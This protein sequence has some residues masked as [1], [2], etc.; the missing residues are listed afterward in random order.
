MARKDLENNLI[1]RA[2]AR[3]NSASE[4]DPSLPGLQA[5][6]KK[7]DD[8]SSASSPTNVSA[9]NKTT[10]AVEGSRNTGKS[11]SAVSEPGPQVTE[12][13]QSTVAGTTGNSESLENGDETLTPGIR[14]TAGDLIVPVMVGLPP[15]AFVMG[16]ESGA[17]NEKPAHQVQVEAFSMSRYEITR[18]QYNVFM[19]DTGSDVDRPPLSQALLPVA[20]IT[21]NEAAAYTRWLSEKTGKR[22]RLPTEEEWEYAARAG[23]MTPYHSGD[24]VFGGANCLTCLDEIPRSAMPVGTFEPNNFGLYDMHGNVAEWTSS[25]LTDN[26]IKDNQNTEQQCT[27]HVVRGGSWRSTRDQVRSS[28]RVGQPVSGRAMGTGIRVVHDGL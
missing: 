24:T 9:G 17:S 28:F 18:E 10:D 3:F 27:K 5:I 23:T 25:C 20:G 7:L 8:L 15:G 21:S 12:P 13:I 22:Y 4:T 1:E 2:R 19:S 11:S 16:S 6:A 14:P 26:H